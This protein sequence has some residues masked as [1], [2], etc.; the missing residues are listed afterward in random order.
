VAGKR[1]LLVLDNAA[2]VEQA[3]PLLPGTPGCLVVVTSR[4][5]LPGLTAVEGAHPIS[6]ELLSPTEARELLVR[7][8]GSDRVDA[9]PAATDEIIDRCARLPLALALVAARAAAR[10]NCPLLTFAEELRTIRPTLDAL[11][12]DEQ[13]ADVRAVFS[14]S[15]QN[16][17]PE[18][19]RMFRLLGL[20]PG[21]ELT[22]PSAASLAGVPV[23]R[24]RTLLAEL[25]RCHM[26]AEHAPGRYALHDLLRAYAAEQ[27]EAH[28]RPDERIEAVHRILDHYLHSA[29][30]AGSLL[31][32]AGTRS[33]WIRP[34]PA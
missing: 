6:L 23:D 22:A 21:P 10:P 12:D 13:T 8:L 2:S 16:L 28:E 11:H 30:A 34:A 32:R 17:G 19:A 20:P 4:R 9:E 1:L 24:A 29:Q 14:W 26:V 31:Y 15:Y 27:A 7:H 5:Q 18:A 3:R 33:A 25:A